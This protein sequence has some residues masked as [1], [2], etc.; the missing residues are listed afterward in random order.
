MKIHFVLFL[1]TII[2]FEINIFDFISQKGY[3][4]VS[5]ALQAKYRNL[6]ET[7]SRRHEGFN[8]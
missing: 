6:A 8:F 4:P 1:E 7:H 3:I 2:L 5:I